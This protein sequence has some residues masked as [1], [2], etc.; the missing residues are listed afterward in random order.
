MTAAEREFWTQASPGVPVGGLARATAR[1]IVQD[2]AEPRARLRAIYD[3]VI[4]NTWRD[5]ATAGCGA[6][7]AGAMLREGKM[8]GKC[9]D[10]NGLMVSLCRAAG[11]PA[12]DVY[13]VRL[14][15]SAQFRSLGRSGNVT[16]A[17]HCRAEVYLEDA[18]WFAVDPADV[19]KVVLEEKL[20]VDSPPVRDLADR[21]FGGWEGNWG[22]YNTLHDVRLAGAPQRPNYH[23]MMYP[24]A[25]DR[26]R[27]IACLDAAQ[28][29]YR[30][31]SREIVA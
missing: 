17:Q 26:E 31:T 2:L 11:F 13:G 14:A 22:A 3:W 10:I 25:M 28:F 21:L 23:F 18:G 8:G 27:T 5:P 1:R 24:C 15:D 6:G 20:P 16:G 29:Q 7:D 9:A 19:R 12:R 30:I 4:A